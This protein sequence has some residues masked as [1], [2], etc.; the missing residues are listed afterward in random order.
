MKITHYSTAFQQKDYVKSSQSLDIFIIAVHLQ[1][2]LTLIKYHYEEKV[3]HFI[4]S[5]HIYT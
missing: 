4:T 2:K 3:Y 5:E 1:S